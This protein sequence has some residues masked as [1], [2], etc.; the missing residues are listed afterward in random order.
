MGR[1]T[2]AAVTSRLQ[3]P[4][5]G[6]NDDIDLERDQFRHEFG[7]ESRIVSSRSEFEPMFPPLHVASLPQAL[8]QLCSE[9]LGISYP[10][11]KCADV[12]NL[13]LLGA[14]GKG[15]SHASTSWRVE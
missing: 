10:Q 5:S 1:G 14:G 13:G 12:T 2:E 15:A 4:A 9:G 8:S 7:E 3:N 6:G 11:Q